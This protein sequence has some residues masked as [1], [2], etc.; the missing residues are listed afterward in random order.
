MTPAEPRSS[1]SSAASAYAGIMFLQRPHHD[2]PK[3]TSTPFGWAASASSKLLESRTRTPASPYIFAVF[4]A[5]YAISTVAR[6]RGLNEISGAVSWT[7]ATVPMRAAVMNF[8]LV[9]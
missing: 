6:V 2:A 1:S 5:S 7:A 9:L 8:I 3:F 4:A